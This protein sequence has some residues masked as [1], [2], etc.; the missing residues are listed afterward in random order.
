MAQW[1]L[2]FSASGGPAGTYCQC[3]DVAT[4]GLAALTVE[5]WVKFDVVNVAQGIVSKWGSTDAN[6]EWALYLDADGKVRFRVATSLGVYVDSPLSDALTANTWYYISGSYT[7]LGFVRLFVNGTAVAGATATLTTNVYDTA[8]TVEFGRYGNANW[9]EGHIA[10]VR[11]SDSERYV[12]S[13]SIP[14]SP[15]QLDA[16]TVAQWDFTEGPG[17]TS[18]KDR[19]YEVTTYDAVITDADWR[20]DIPTA[21]WTDTTPYWGAPWTIYIDGTDRTSLVEVSTI[22]IR[23]TMGSRRDTAEFLIPLVDSDDIS[24]QTWHTVNIWHGGVIE[25]GGLGMIHDH[26]DGGVAR[27]TLVTCVDWT[28]LLD[29]RL[30]EYNTK[31]TGLTAGQIAVTAMSAYCTEIN[32]ALTTAGGH[33]YAGEDVG[34]IIYDFATLND[35]IKDAADASSYVYYVKTEN[36][37]ANPVNLYFQPNT[38]PE[39]PFDLGTTTATEGPFALNVT[40][41]TAEGTQLRNKV[42]VKYADGVITV[43]DAASQTTYGYTLEM[44]TESETADA[45]L[46][47]LIGNALLQLYG[48]ELQTGTVVCWQDGLAP[49]QIVHVTHDSLGIDDDYLIQEIQIAPDGETTVYELTLGD[50]AL[51]LVEKLRPSGSGTGNNS[52]K[53][54]LFVGRREGPHVGLFRTRRPDFDYNIYLQA[55]DTGDRPFLDVGS[56]DY[57]TNSAWLNIG[58]V[59]ETTGKAPIRLAASTLADPNVEEHPRLEIDAAYLVNTTAIPGAVSTLD[60]LSD[61]AITAPV[62]G[63]VLTYDSVS[64]QWENLV[65]TPVGHIH[66]YQEDYTTSCN[67]VLT[68]FTLANEYQTAT[69]QVWLNGLLQRPGTDY[70]ESSADGITFTTAPATSDVLLVAYIVKYGAGY[71]YWPT[72]FWAEYW[73]T[74][75][76]V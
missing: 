50:K 72:G 57:G 71:G 70:T 21:L 61:V 65:A 53:L 58:Y 28:A 25:F 40:S 17:A 6:R 56:V 8:Q 68:V 55:T 30:T 3:G 60:D 14:K 7:G 44:V 4:G 43:E 35:V 18:I 9:L 32:A 67:G 59:D 46:A 73:Q 69:T 74:G 48:D 36:Y 66:V 29:A 12:A 31:F 42:T 63:D 45:S 22:R 52:G 38:A 37:A 11:I 47:T 26:G 75:Y 41:W 62:H 5:A 33:V 20:T 2:E 13:Y 19:K 16:N 39:A 51:G 15:P 10:Y 64:G 23:K 1:S 27:N 76:W 49:G 34:E 54:N 24:F